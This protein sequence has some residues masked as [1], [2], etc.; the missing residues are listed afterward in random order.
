MPFYMIRIDLI[1]L[2]FESKI[3]KIHKLLVLKL[4]INVVIL[5]KLAN[6]FPYCI[7]ELS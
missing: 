6:N 7:F 4:K 3:M 1:I 5:G 2:Y